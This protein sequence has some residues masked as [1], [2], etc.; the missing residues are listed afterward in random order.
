MNFNRKDLI[1]HQHRCLKKQNDLPFTR[2]YVTGFNRI[3]LWIPNTFRRL[4]FPMTAFQ[5]YPRKF[6]CHHIGG[7]FCPR[8][9]VGQGWSIKKYRETEGSVERGRSRTE[10]KIDYQPERMEGRGQSRDKTDRNTIHAW[11]GFLFEHPPA[12]SSALLI[13]LNV[14]PDLPY[15][16]HVTD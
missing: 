2:W 16:R 15:L 5:R 9:G 8:A 14:A 3:R 11:G 7:A 10:D 6:P 1:A 4:T 13:R 12:C